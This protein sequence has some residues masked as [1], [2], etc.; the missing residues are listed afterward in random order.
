MIVRSIPTPPNV[1]N[2]PIIVR[3][4]EQCHISKS[5]NEQQPAIFLIFRDQNPAEETK[6]HIYSKLNIFSSC[7]E[8]VSEDRQ[9]GNIRRRHRIVPQVLLADPFECLPLLPPNHSAPFSANK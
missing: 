2:L 4:T 6:K 7:S 1:T 3:G 5:G 8:P 9:Q